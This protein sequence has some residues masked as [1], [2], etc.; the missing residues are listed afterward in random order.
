MN[1]TEIFIGF[2]VGMLIYIAIVINFIKKELN[3]KKGNESR[4]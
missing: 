1:L 4:H 3:D 2:S